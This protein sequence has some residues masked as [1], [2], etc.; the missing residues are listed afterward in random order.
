MQR[1]TRVLVLV[2]LVLW[3]SSV[4]CVRDGT[5]RAAGWTVVQTQHV[6]LYSDVSQA[7]AT[8]LAETFERQH[9]GLAHIFS[10]CAAVAAEGVDEVVVFARQADLAELVGREFDGIYSAPSDG[11][12]PVAGRVVTHAD[13]VRDGASG[14]FTH[15]LTHRFVAACFPELPPWLNEGLACTFEGTQVR[16]GHIVFGLPRYVIADVA[17]R[18]TRTVRGTYVTAMP[19]RA[20]PTASELVE[21]TPAAFYDA[22]TGPSVSSAAEALSGRYA[23]AW[24]LVHLLEAGGNPD[25]HVR[26]TAFLADL[27][28]G[29]LPARDAFAR[30]FRDVDLDA[31]LRAHLR[32]GTYVVQRIPFDVGDSNL[33]DARAASTGETHL[34]L[35]EV[36][37]YSNHGGV[38][39]ARQHLRAIG[40]SDPEFARGRLLELTLADDA[41]IV[42]GVDAL[43]RLHSDDLDVLHAR[44]F[45]A[46]RSEDP[47]AMRAALGALTRRGG[48]RPS[49]HHEIASLLLALGR[50]ETAMRHAL[51]ASVGTPGSYRVHTTRARIAAALGRFE[52][53]RRSLGVALLI[54]S[55]RAPL[56]VPELLA[57]VAEI[58]RLTPPALAEPPRLP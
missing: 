57:L 7:R 3:V 49:D 21:L 47:A 51:V 40:R 33:A 18:E 41:A 24:G 9:R 29:Q 35:A 6:R 44:A 43:A 55:E 11:L 53:A 58:E 38:E 5:S 54:A 8:E 31:A 20:V 13:A 52:Q 15:E 42:A 16:D 56:R 12:V 46:A 17:E 10:D 22:T 19:G 25:L 36:E 23:A 2:V 48:L 1:S 30:R 34:L 39:R 4:G 27:R 50:P 45:L 26:F 28:G 32:G 14:T 37:L